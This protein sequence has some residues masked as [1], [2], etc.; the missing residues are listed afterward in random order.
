MA[1][2]DETQLIGRARRASEQK[3]GKYEDFADEPLQIREV[4]FL[5]T[6]DFR[7]YNIAGVS[8]AASRLLQAG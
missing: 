4:L 6:A 2:V 1:A 5:D 8:D 3:P 7:L